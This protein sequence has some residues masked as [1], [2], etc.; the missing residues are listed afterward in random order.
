MSKSKKE[1]TSELSEILEH[2]NIGLSYFDKNLNLVISNKT[3]G[4]LLGFP[5]SVRI[6]GTNLSEFF[7][8]N[9]ERGEYGDGDIEA[10]ITE[11]LKLA[12]LRKPHDFERIRPDGSVLR[13][14]GMPTEDGGFVTTYSDITELYQSKQALEETNANLDD[15]MRERTK[16]LREREEQ[17]AEQAE[18]LTEIMESTNVGIAHYDKELRLT[19]A[20]QRYYDITEVPKELRLRGIKLQTLFKEC[21][22][23]QFHSLPEENETREE[24]IQKELHLIS[25]PDH[26]HYLHPDR[27]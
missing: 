21:D 1:R 18:L 26:A 6:P 8:F 11:R 22:I 5:D 10:Q 14:Q 27:G 13:I 19:V 7:R 25:N 15:L 20:N 24:R 2:L 12:R 9:A 4:V 17:L 23:S 16:S 3:L